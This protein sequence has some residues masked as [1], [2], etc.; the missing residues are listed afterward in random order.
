M[1][2]LSVP[3]TSASRPS[4]SQSSSEKRTGRCL[5]FGWLGTRQASQV[6]VQSTSR[7]GLRCKY[8]PASV[9]GMDA[10]PEAV[11]VTGPNVWAV[12]TEGDVRD[13]D[14]FATYTLMS[15]PGIPG[16]VAPRTEEK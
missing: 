14:G 15:G 5:F 1:A 4:S 2:L 9:S 10:T 3:A 13:G 6:Y 7:K 16:V 8:T 12:S 11:E